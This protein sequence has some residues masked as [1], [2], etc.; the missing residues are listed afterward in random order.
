DAPIMILALTS[1]SLGPGELYDQAATV[2]QQKLSQVKGVGDVTLGGSSLPAVRVELQPSALFKYGIGLEDVRA[3]RAA[4]NANSPKGVIEE[5]ERRFQLYTNDQARKAD[6]YRPLVIAYRNGAAVRL[7][8]IADVEDSVENLRNQG[9][10][11]GTPSVLVLLSREPNA[12]IIDTVDRIRALLPELRASLPRDIDIAV[13]S[14]RST[15]IR[16]SLRE[17]ERSLVIAIGLVILVVYLFL[18]TARATITPGV[19]VPV[20][21]V[22]TFGVMSLMGYSLDNLSLMALPIAT[23]FVMDDAIVVLENISRHVEA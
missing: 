12:N 3:A 23:G 17:V 9:I 20:S 4:A 5:R 13:A 7:S 2:L 16:A 15:T 10:A 6:Q 21:L 19:V 18:R 8:D 14:D 22:G 1:H 11:Q